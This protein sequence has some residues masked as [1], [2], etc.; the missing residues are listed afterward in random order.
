V[1]RKAE[2]S[3]AEIKVPYFK[4]IEL[5]IGGSTDLYIVPTVAGSYGVVCTVTGHEAAGMTG[6]ITVAP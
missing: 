6:T 5:L 4:A 2:D 1:T 3:Q